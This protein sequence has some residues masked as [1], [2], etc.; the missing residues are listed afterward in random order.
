LRLA[1]EPDEVHKILMAKVIFHWYESGTGWNFGELIGERLNDLRET[2]I[3]ST[4]A[5]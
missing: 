3:V 4:S 1:D 2:G 5:T